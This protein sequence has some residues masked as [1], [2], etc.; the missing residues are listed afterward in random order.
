MKHNGCNCH[1]GCKYLECID[2]HDGYEFRCSRFNDR[3]K[4]FREE[5]GA[6]LS[7]WVMENVSMDCYEPNETQELLNDMKDSLKELKLLISKK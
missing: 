3:Y 4:A 6:K 2:K 1:G 7:T 5:N